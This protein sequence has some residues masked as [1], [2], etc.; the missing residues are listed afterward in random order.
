[1]REDIRKHENNENMQKLKV[2]SYGSAEKDWKT[3]RNP[4]VS[5]CIRKRAP[6]SSVFVE[7]RI[8]RQKPDNPD[9]SVFFVVFRFKILCFLL[10]PE[11]KHAKLLVLSH[12]SAEKYFSTSGIPCVSRHFCNRGTNSLVFA[13]LRIPQPPTPPRCT[14]G[15]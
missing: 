7:F 2:W 6:N 5:W 8:L 13:A 14:L 12:A 9:N 3:S 11:R 15:V 4:W 1:M 10:M